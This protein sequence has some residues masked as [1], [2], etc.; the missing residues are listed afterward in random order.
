M[1]LYAVQL[2]SS[3][4]LETNL[5]MLRQVMAPLSEVSGPKLVVLPECVMSFDGEPDAM[6]TLSEPLGEGSMQRALSQLAQEHRCTLVAGTIPIHAPDG[7]FYASCL[8]FDDTGQRIGHY[9]KLHLFDVDVADGV[10]RYRESDTTAPGQHVEVIDTPFGKLGIAVCYDVR[11]PELFR[12]MVA[13]GAQ[14]IALPSAFT[15]VTGEAHWQPL[16]QARAI[17]N[18]CYLIAA[19]QGGTHDHGRMTW[20]QSMIVSPWGEVL[21]QAQQSPA[22]VLASFDADK[23][24]QIRQQMPT[25][26][27]I[28]MPITAAQLKK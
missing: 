1:K 25:Q 24:H 10:G 15:Q 13:K 6:A 7:R 2:C 5:A 19:N 9:N 27:H 28:R 16:L 22:M 4:S 20:G 11:F 21:A 3:S 14:I 17:E 12:A 8:V 23:I 26:Q 18:Q